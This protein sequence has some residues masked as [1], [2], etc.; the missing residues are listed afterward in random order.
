MF[1]ST[2]T[3]NQ[4][5]IENIVRSIVTGSSPSGSIPTVNS[6]FSAPTLTQGQ[7]TNL[8]IDVSTVFNPS[9]NS[10]TYTV[11]DLDLPPGLTFDSTTKSIIVDPSSPPPPGPQSSGSFAVPIT[12]DDHDGHVVNSSFNLTVNP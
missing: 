1:A 11:S 5:T 2:A 8:P 9:A 6:S 4:D 10:W 3:V 7:T 12:V